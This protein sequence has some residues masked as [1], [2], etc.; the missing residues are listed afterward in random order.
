MAVIGP[1]LESLEQYCFSW[2]SSK[3]YPSSGPKKTLENTYS[4]SLVYE[5]AQ[6]L[7]SSTCLVNPDS[8][9]IINTSP[10]DSRLDSQVL[11]QEDNGVCGHQQVNSKDSG[12]GIRFRRLFHHDIDLVNSIPPSLT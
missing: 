1:I 9:L 2:G 6:D 8:S 12:H 11:S 3:E 10:K 4:H 7:S 5:S